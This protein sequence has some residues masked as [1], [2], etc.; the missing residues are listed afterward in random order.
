MTGVGHMIVGVGCETSMRQSKSYD[1]KMP[2]GLLSKENRTCG[3]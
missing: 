1:I 3:R 2:K